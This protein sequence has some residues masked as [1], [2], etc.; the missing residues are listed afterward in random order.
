MFGKESLKSI[1]QNTNCD[2]QLKIEKAQID[3][4]HVF[5]IRF[6]QGLLVPTD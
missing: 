3:K 2:V 5:T 1:N 6:N 4:N